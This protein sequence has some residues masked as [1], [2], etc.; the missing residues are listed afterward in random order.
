M[1]RGL[2]CEPGYRFGMVIGAKTFSVYLGEIRVGRLCSNLDKALESRVVQISPEFGAGGTYPSSS[3]TG[4][5]RMT[6]RAV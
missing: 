4:L 2:I 3:R 1:L 5:G 6:L